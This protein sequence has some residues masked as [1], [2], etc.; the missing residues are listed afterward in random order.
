M[1]YILTIW[2]FYLMVLALLPCSDASNQCND[3]TAAVVNTQQRHDHDKDND[4]GCSPSCYC[5][6][7]SASITSFDFKV[8][9]VKEPK[10]VFATPAITLRDCR[11]I[12]RY[13]GN[14]WN[15]PRFTT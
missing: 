6:C 3:D 15:P 10:L 11:F 12:S 9:E 7:C 13:D 8:P 5:N 1:R 4:D 14:I 2:T